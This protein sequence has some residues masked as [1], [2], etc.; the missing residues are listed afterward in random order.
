ASSSMHERQSTTPSHFEK[1]AFRWKI[2]AVGSFFSVVTKTQVHSGVKQLF[3]TSR[4]PLRSR[5][6]FDRTKFAALSTNGSARTL[7]NGDPVGGEERSQPQ[8]PAR[9]WISGEGA[10]RSYALYNQGSPGVNARDVRR[11]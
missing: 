5:T 4:R 3:V 6:M 8:R 1:I 7:R 10:F 2:S 11:D 9:R